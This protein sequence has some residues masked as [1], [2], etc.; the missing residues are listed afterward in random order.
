VPV[1]VSV[2]VPNYNYGRYLDERLRSILT[3]TF[4]D[5]EVIVVDDASTDDSRAVIERHRHDRR[6]RVQAFDTNSGTTYQRWNDGAALASGEYVWFAGADDSSEPEFL[7]S[8]V[9]ILESR[10]RV[11]MA[12]TRSTLIDGQGVASKVTPSH[13]RWNRN[14]VSTSEEEV[15]FWLDQRTIPTASAVLMRRALFADCGGFDTGLRLA[16]DHLLWLQLLRRGDVGYEARPLTRFRVHDGTVRARVG[17]DSVVEERYRV[18]GYLL[19]EFDVSAQAREA[20][21]NRL[22][23]NWADCLL[24]GPRVGWSRHRDIM[25]AAAG[26][27]RFA[28]RRMLRIAAEQRLGVRIRS[29]YAI[30]KYGW[31]LRREMVERLRG[32]RVQRQYS[33]HYRLARQAYAADRPPAATRPAVHGFG[34]VT[35]RPGHPAPPFEIP[36]QH[37]A[38]AA[39]LARAADKAL[40]DSARCRFVPKL[41][42]APVA[43]R[44]SDVAEIASR[45]VIAI[46]V[47]DPLGLDGLRDVSDP[48]L[49]A[50]EQR[51]YGSYLIVD[52]VYVYRSPI[53]ERIPSAS[54]LWHYDNHPREVLKVMIY[55]TEVTPGS[56]PFEYLHDPASN[57]PV[58]GAPLAPLHVSSRVPQAVV[59]RHVANGAAPTPVTG[60][61]GTVIVFD[62]NVIHRGTLARTSHRDVLVLQVRPALTRAEPRIDPRWT[63]SFLNQD[64]NADPFDSVPH[65]K[66]GV[67]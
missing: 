5:L 1:S 21:R 58:M 65:P 38:A 13:P 45:D 44:T 10:P 48:L 4:S 2:I 27:D 64:V 34:V 35:I 40:S 49:D 47:R 54:W 30:A 7:E 53:C 11:G 19:R 43:P 67:S 50:L 57:R 24:S 18:F 59:D 61:Q 15:P 31:R 39:R 17:G 16:A 56:A 9:A 42:L 8:L 51:V 33:R 55:L 20:L 25:R 22:A 23:R 46:Q 62:D 66:A 14:F 37:A 12:Y 6:V 32:A 26:V 63:G 52:K 28:A 29:P 41:R 36:A 3:Q 60:P